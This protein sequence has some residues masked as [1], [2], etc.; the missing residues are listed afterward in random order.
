[1]QLTELAQSLGRVEA[2]VDLLL[3][4]ATKADRRIASME[5]KMWWGSGAMAVLMAIVVPKIR[6]ILG[7]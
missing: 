2:K 6:T 5:R 4:H 1:M 7:M 3:D